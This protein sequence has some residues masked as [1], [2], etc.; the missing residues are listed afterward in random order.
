MIFKEYDLIFSP[1]GYPPVLTIFSFPESL[2][3]IYFC[4]PPFIFLRHC[5]Y[6]NDL[7]LLKCLRSNFE[8]FSKLPLH[9]HPYIHP[10]FLFSRTISDLNVPKLILDFLVSSFKIFKSTFFVSKIQRKVSLCALTLLIFNT[11]LYSIKNYDLLEF[12]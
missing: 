12:S 2:K 3:F 6:I 9:V 4:L 5:H 7:Q 11:L 10:T 1:F 8:I